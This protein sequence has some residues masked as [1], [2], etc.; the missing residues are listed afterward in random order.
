MGD[1]KDVYSLAEE[2]AVDLS[3]EQWVGDTGYA[4]SIGG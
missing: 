4:I 3:D 2:H 1:A